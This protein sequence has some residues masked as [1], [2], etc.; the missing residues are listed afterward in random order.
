MSRS[1][2]P[3]EQV[4]V[5]ERDERAEWRDVENA[6]RTYIAQAKP[7]EVYVKP[8]RVPLLVRLFGWLYPLVSK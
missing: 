5:L 1:A 4:D 7:Y 6:F 8:R 2:L 3:R